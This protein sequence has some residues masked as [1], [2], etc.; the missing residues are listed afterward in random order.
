MS[1]RI[2]DTKEGRVRDTEDAERVEVRTLAEARAWLAVN[3]GRAE[4]VWLVTWKKRPGAPHVGYGDLVD[5]LLCFG[6]IDNLSRKLDDARSMLWVAPRRAG[7]G[8]S[9][10]NKEKLV[11][12]EADQDVARLGDVGGLAEHVAHQHE[13]FGF[14]GPRGLGAFVGVDDRRADLGRV[15][16]GGLEVFGADL[17]L[18]ERRVAAQAADLD[19]G[20]G[21]GALDAERVVEHRHRVEVAGLAEQLAPGVNH[22]LDV[23]VAQPR[24]LGDAG[25][26]V[27]VVVT[28]E[29]EIDAKTDRAHVRVLLGG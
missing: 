29:L 13:V 19:A 1:R 25:L 8:W 21:A 27:F 24:R 3:H 6:W 28:D 4:G 26:E 5:E 23:G 2:S 9:K 7:S 18:A 10:V 11:R 17:R 20:R 15:A 14:G 22:R 12:L 16:D